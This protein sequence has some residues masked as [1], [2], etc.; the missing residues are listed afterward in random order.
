MGSESVKIVE[1]APSSS[2]SVSTY[3]SG[4]DSLI[5]G[6]SYSSGGSYSFGSGGSSS[7]SSGIGGGSSYSSKEVI[8]TGGSSLSGIGG[9]SS[10]YSYK[11]SSSSG[12]EALSGGSG[13]YSSYSYSSSSG[14]ALNGSAISGEYSATL[15][16]SSYDTTTIR[17][18]S[19]TID[20]AQ[21]L[22]KVLIDDFSKF[23]HDHEEEEIEHCDEAQLE[24]SVYTRKVSSYYSNMPR[25]KLSVHEIDGDDTASKKSSIT[26]GSKTVQFSGGEISGASRVSVHSDGGFSA[27]GEP[28]EVTGSSSKSV[29]VSGGSGGSSSSSSMQMSSSSSGS[30]SM[31][32][33]AGGSSS[34]SSGMVMSAVL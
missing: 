4:G 24:S 28:L 5:G 16:P 21:P 9:G 26:G 19:V 10:S 8:S 32:M 20:K 23:E 15:T 33:S 2:Y 7:F 13:G 29:M 25:S 1:S 27:V 22:A 31:S 12:G 18:K 3:K 14:G 11:S 6:S 34:S 30:S 17:K